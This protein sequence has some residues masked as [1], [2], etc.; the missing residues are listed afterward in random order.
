MYQRIGTLG[1][2]VVDFNE[3]KS[4]FYGFVESVGNPVGVFRVTVFYDG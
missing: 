1:A 2:V 4:R 3:K